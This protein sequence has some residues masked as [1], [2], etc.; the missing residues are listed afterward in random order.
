MIIM[1]KKIFL[2]ALIISLSFGMLNTIPDVD[3]NAP[4]T[5]SSS[6]DPLLIGTTMLSHSN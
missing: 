3:A 4:P 6:S 2:Y 1:T 5:T